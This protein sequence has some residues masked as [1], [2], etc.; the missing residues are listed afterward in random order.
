MMD[1][2]ALAVLPVSWDPAYRIIPTRFP[3]ANVYER[4]A[5]ADE[6]AA[7]IALEWLTND[8]QR[9]RRGE[10][11]RVPESERASGRGAGYVMAAFT[12]L[13]EGGGRFHDGEHGAFYVGRDLS[14]TVAETVHHRENF[15]RATRQRPMQLAMRVLESAI[16]A[17][18]HDLR[19]LGSVV[20][21]I[22]DPE[23]YDASQALARRLMSAGSAGVVYDS[24]RRRGGECAALFRPRPVSLCRP[25]LYLEYGWDGSRIT[26]V[27]EQRAG[28]GDQERRR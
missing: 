20:P 6:Q 10:R 11:V 12:H 24:V 26:E 23:S 18:L 9:D 15:M 21:A 8:R 13:H 4:I 19:G 1:D 22:Y 25:A 14:T 16:E 2:A 27:Q 3:P 28:G 5:S 17:P 7:V